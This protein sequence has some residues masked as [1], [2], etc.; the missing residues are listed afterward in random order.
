MKGKKEEEE[1][2][3]FTWS[4]LAVVLSPKITKKPKKS[5]AKNTNP[6][7][8]FHGLQ[9]EAILVAVQ[10]LLKIFMSEKQNITTLDLL[11]L[12]FNSQCKENLE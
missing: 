4:L 5:W 11:V 6:N 3:Y 2:S 10:H 7:D 9:L 8:S 12:H 1:N